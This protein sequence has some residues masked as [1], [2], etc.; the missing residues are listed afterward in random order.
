MKIFLLWDKGEEQAPEVVR[1][2]IRLWR[3]RNP[4]DEVIVFDG[5]DLEKSLAD[6]PVVTDQLEIQARADIFR[7]KL[8]MEHGGVW[9][10]ATLLPVRSLAE[11]LPDLLS[12]GFFAFRQCHRDRILSNWFFAASTPNHPLVVG[13]Y[14]ALVRY[15]S[16]PRRLANEKSRLWRARRKLGGG[17][18]STIRRGP[19][20]PYPYFAAHYLFEDMINSDPS[21]A[22]LWKAI[23]VWPV[24]PTHALQHARFHNRM[25]SDDFRAAI[26]TLL[27]SAPVQKLDWRHQWP[28]EVFSGQGRTTMPGVSLTEID[29]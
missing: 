25:A 22:A 12:A 19:R 2:V 8:V 13:W 1:N 27:G 6:T 3:E 14:T 29:R 10:D 26:P 7:V 24:Q 21:M 28:D 15:F 11:W 17:Y 20:A 9:A 18:M 23:P 16:T 5:S 4:N